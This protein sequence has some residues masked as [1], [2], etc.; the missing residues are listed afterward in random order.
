MLFVLKQ[1]GLIVFLSKTDEFIALWK[2][3]LSKDAM[4]WNMW[5][6]TE[7]R[8]CLMHLYDSYYKIIAADWLFPL[9]AFW[10]KYFSIRKYKII[11]FIN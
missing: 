8:V 1:W 2:F 11:L 4:I 5:F 10:K 9:E 7:S 3:L 6:E